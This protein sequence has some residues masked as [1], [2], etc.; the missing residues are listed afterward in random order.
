MNEYTGYTDSN[1]SVLNFVHMIGDRMT[2]LD[3]VEEFF[4]LQADIRALSLLSRSSP[5]WKRL[6]PWEGGV[7]HHGKSAVTPH[8]LC[9]NPVSHADGR[10]FF[11]LSPHAW[12]EGGKDR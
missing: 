5:A 3:P 2:L 1:S 6:V 4:C 8:W 10:T 11:S 7:L 9:W 12:S